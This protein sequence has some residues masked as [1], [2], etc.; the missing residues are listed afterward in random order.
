MLQRCKIYSASPL[1][2]GNTLAASLHQQ[3]YDRLV[4][5]I[6][7][8]QQVD[9]QE[10]FDLAKSNELHATTQGMLLAPLQASRNVCEMNPVAADD[11]GG[12]LR[13]FRSRIVTKHP[14]RTMLTAS[15]HILTAVCIGPR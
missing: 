15:V 6:L 10:L 8:G 2:E 14:L 13:L 1:S 3:L 5:C 12:N 7:G 9:L 4:G 11:G